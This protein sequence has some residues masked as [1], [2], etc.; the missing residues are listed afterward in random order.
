M[1][2]AGLWAPGVLLALTSPV[3]VL[4]LSQECATRV[5]I[6]AWGCALQH[7]VKSSNTP[8]VSVLAFVLFL[9]FYSHR[10]DLSFC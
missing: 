7:L 5:L 9:F 4:R 1:Y 6:E 2:L 8:V 10:D 3:C